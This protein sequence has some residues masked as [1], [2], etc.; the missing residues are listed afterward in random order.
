MTIVKFENP[1]IEFNISTQIFW[2]YLHIWSKTNHQK[3]LNLNFEKAN[4]DLGDCTFFLW[5]IGGTY[6]ER[7]DIFQHSDCCS[8]KCFSTIFNAFSLSL[9]HKANIFSILN[10]FSKTEIVL[11]VPQLHNTLQII[12]LLLYWRFLR[13]ILILAKRWTLTDSVSSP[14]QIPRTWGHS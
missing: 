9:S 14:A 2:K 13:L 8:I 7:I 6:F 11:L 5:R 12:F 1:K 10:S 4:L 3:W